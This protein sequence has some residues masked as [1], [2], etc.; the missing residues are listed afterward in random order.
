MR[1]ELAKQI[2]A[3]LDEGKIP[4]RKP[5][6]G[7]GG[8][9]PKNVQTGK[10]YSGGNA[11]LLMLQG[12]SHWAGYGQWRKVG[13]QVRK[14]ETATTIFRPM[15]ITVDRGTPD[16]RTLPGR[17]ATCKVFSASQQDGWAAPKVETHAE[18][19]LTPNAKADGIVERMENRPT[20]AH[21]G[22]SAQ[23]SPTLDRV[24]MPER[25]QFE[26]P[27]GYY[28]TIFHELSHST[29]HESRCARKGF[30]DFSRHEYSKEELVAE[31]SAMFLNAECGIA[32]AVME[33][34]AAYIQ[35]WQRRLKA[36]PEM[37][38]GVLSGA[39]RSADYVLGL[40]SH[41]RQDARAAVKSA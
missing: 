26:T 23:Y 9:L 36:T 15:M 19:A 18:A 11:F 7:N 10:H 3:L 40:D 38:D 5:W 14:G 24:T 6:T 35:T 22:D 16:E 8:G 17:F 4:W 39:Q 31:F 1:D 32:P 27:E 21:G 34:A 28:S 13:G 20:I 30:K 37:L 25:D 12:E 29:G 33:N 41:A 2:L